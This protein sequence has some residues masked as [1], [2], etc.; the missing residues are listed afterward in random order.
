M[1]WLILGSFML[2]KSSDKSHMICSVIK[3]KTPFGFLL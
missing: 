3:A 2:E 1:T